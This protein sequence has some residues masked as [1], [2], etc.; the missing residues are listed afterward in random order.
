M[1]LYSYPDTVHRVLLRKTR[2]VNATY[3]R[4]P[5]N[6]KSSDWYHPCYSGLQVQSTANSPAARKLYDKIDSGL[7]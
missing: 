7:L 4:Q 3:K 2:D 1:L 5:H 6:E